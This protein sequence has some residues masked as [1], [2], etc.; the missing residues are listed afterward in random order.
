MQFNLHLFTIIFMLGAVQGIFL[1]LLLIGKKGNRTANRILALL[2]LFYSLYITNLVL[3]DMDVYIRIPRLTWLFAGLPFLFGPLHYLYAKF[4]IFPKLKFTKLR[5]LHLFPFVIF[6]VY[7]FPFIFIINEDILNF[8]HYYNEIFVPVGLIFNSAVILQG[9]IYMV[10]TLRLLMRYSHQIKNCFS[11]IEKINLNWLRNIT[12]ITMCVW[13]LVVVQE[14]LL[15]AGFHTLLEGDY[16]IAFAMSI[17]IFVM[18]YLGWRQPEI[19]LQEDIEELSGQFQPFQSPA[20][21]KATLIYHGRGKFTKLR[22]S[23][24]DDSSLDGERSTKYEKSGLSREKAK[25]YLQ[26][27]IDLMNEEKPFTDN[28]LTLHLLAEKL[29]ITAHNLSEVVNTQLK[30][31]F[32]DFVNQYRV[33]EVKKAFTD[34]KKMHYTLLAIAFDAGFN[35]KS[36]FNAIFKK[37]TGMTP[38]QYQRVTTSAKS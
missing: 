32:F 5:W 37:H 24:S 12:L 17:I 18:G 38:S 21:K 4:L 11:S 14:L 2:I 6:K 27:L 3:V 26:N 15:F 36:S 16:P 35:S 9:I 30:Q 33:E 34:P 25:K 20:R 19:F 29:S 8:M 28:N 13:I 31:H 7:F 1:V 22:V 10:L 23:V